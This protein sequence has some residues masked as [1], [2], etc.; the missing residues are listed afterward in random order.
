[1]EPW[2]L[3]APFLVRPLLIRFY[4][5]LLAAMVAMTMWP[6]LIL[7]LANIQYDQHII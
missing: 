6:G 1:M 4:K 2:I 5:F 3:F 7:G